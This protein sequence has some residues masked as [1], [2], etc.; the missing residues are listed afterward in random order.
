MSKMGQNPA[1]NGNPA[2]APAA[3]SAA[4]PSTSRRRPIASATTPQPGTTIM[5]KREPTPSTVPI[6]AGL[7]P[8]SANHKGR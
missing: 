2:A 4:T 3:T 5:R 8:R 7:R 6:S 1:M